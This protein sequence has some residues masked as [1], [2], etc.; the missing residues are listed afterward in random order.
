MNDALIIKVKNKLKE[1][2]NPLTNRDIISDNI[3]KSVE[4]KND[5]IILILE[6]DPSKL[7]TMD[8]LKNNVEKKIEELNEGKEIQV[9]LTAHNSLNENK[10]S[11]N[12]I[13]KKNQ[14]LNKGQIRVKTKPN[15]VKRVIAIASGK[16]G[17]GKSTVASKL[18]VALAMARNIET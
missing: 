9:I 16:G 1:I 13:N 14:N 3:L 4:I 7:K 17:V 6:I 10:N 12:D 2:Y 15:G 11:K 8:D 5:V 18:A